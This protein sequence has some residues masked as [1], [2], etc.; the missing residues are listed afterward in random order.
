MF[1]VRL[2]NTKEAQE[3]GIWLKGTSW[4]TGSNRS[5]AQ[6]STPETQEVN[7]CSGVAL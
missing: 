1:I 4:Q 5:L 7:C 3:D 6:A 2:G